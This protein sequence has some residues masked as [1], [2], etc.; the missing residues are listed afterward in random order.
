MSKHSHRPISSTV[1]VLHSR[2]KVAAEPRP[3]MSERADDDFA[4]IQVHILTYV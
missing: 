2:R 4:C 3:N 1:E